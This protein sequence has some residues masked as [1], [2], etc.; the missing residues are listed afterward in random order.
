M[1]AYA[2]YLNQIIRVNYSTYHRSLTEVHEER[3]NMTLRLPQYRSASG[4]L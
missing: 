4:T 1:R 3:Q 2:D